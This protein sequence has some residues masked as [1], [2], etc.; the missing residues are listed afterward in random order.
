MV[1]VL[2]YACSFLLG[3]ILVVLFGMMT[4]A[5][6]LRLESFLGVLAVLMGLCSFIFNCSLFEVK[7]MKSF[8]CKRSLV[9]TH[10]VGNVNI[11]ANF[12]F[13]Y[14]LQFSSLLAIIDASKSEIEIKSYMRIIF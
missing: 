9:Q 2:N 12:V 7:V 14:I 6:L 8:K 13:P 10:E 5:L 3:E 1:V 4:A 11:I